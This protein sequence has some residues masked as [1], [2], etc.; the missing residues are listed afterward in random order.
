MSEAIDIHTHLAPA[1]QTVSSA[2]VH[3][4]AT[5]TVTLR[6]IKAV[7]RAIESSAVAAIGEVG[8]DA[9]RGA[10]LDAQEIIFRHYI[11]LSE[12]LRKP[13][14][15]HC[16]RAWERLLGIHSELRPTQRW[17]IHGFRGKPELARRLLDAGMFIS[18]GPRYNPATAAI[19][20]SDRLLIETDDDPQADIDTLAAT[21]PAY[22]PA[23]SLRFLGLDGADSLRAVVNSP[24]PD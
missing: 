14:I 23:T 10:P 20:P 6:Q 18:L 24:L 3:P 21:L 7:D 4:W 2:G 5:D 19:I 11:E 17:A 8:L 13:L 1:G 12:K 22:D 16:V 15:I 9:L